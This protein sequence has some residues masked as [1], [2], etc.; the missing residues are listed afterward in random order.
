MALDLGKLPDLLDLDDDAL[1][2]H[3]ADVADDLREAEARVKVLRGRRIAV[4]ENARARTP[5]ITQARLAAA[6]QVSEVAVIQA[7]RR[8]DEAKAKAS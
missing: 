5:A 6:A 7:L 2:A 1:V 4:Y 3:L 8:A